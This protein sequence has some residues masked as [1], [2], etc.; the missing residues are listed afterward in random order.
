MNMSSKF[1]VQMLIDNK[2]KLKNNNKL[3][4]SKFKIYGKY[5]D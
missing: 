3:I 1:I 2:K 5:K 4:L